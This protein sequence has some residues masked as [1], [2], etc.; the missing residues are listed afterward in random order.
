L[1]DVL[2]IPDDELNR[3]WVP[4][5]DEGPNKDLYDE[6]RANLIAFLAFS[7]G[8]MAQFAGTGFIIAGAKKFAVVLTAKHVL[9]EGVLRIQRP[10]SASSNGFGP[11]HFRTPDLELK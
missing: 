6:L 4:M 9:D 1:E 3:E 10:E 8:R 2:P 7:R 11:V 5:S